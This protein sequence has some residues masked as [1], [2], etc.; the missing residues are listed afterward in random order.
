MGTIHNQA[1]FGQ[2]ARV[3]LMPGDPLRAQWIADT[4]LE[5]T[6]KFNE[7]RNMLGFTGIFQGQR[8]SV[9]GGGMGIPSTGIY[10][11]ELY[12]KYDVDTIIRIGS[13]GAYSEELK[14]YDILLADCSYSE[15][16]YASTYSGYEPHEVYPSELLNQ[17]IQSVGDQLLISLRR[18]TIHS[19]DCFYRMDKQALHRIRDQHGCLA[20]EME[21]FAL[22]HNAA[23]AGKYA[24]CLLTVS[25]H[26]ITHEKAAPDQRLRCFT[27][28]M[29]IALEAGARRAEVIS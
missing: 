17:Q 25:D 18:G 7:E 10:T 16:T 8:L 19:T 29:K 2:I 24:A 27:D 21:S 11:H 12:H 15:S 5:E 6:V 4:Y 23:V 22:F 1:E 13:C 28:M 26:A 9:M 3:V 14:M 20:V